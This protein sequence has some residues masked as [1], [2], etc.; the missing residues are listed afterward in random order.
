MS[1]CMKGEVEDNS[2]NNTSDTLHGHHTSF[3]P[4]DGFVDG[5]FLAGKIRDIKLQSGCW[6]IGYSP[7]ADILAVGFQGRLDF[8]ETRNYTC[9]HSVER[10]D[11]VSAIEWCPGSALLGD[12]HNH[13]TSALVAVAGLGNGQ[14]SVYQLD[15]ASLE[16][17]GAKVLHEFYM[18]AQV[19]SMAFK[20]LQQSGSIVLAI[21][22][23]SGRIA[24]CT[25][26][27]NSQE[28]SDEVVVLHQET[29]R[30]EQD[31][32]VLGLDVQVLK[33]DKI[34]LACSTKSGKVLI[35]SIEWQL[36][37]KRL[38]FG[39][40]LWETQ[41]NG[42]VRSLTFSGS[43]VL[44]GGYDK[45]LVIVDTNLMAITQDQSL[46]GT[47]N[48]IAL[49]PMDRFFVVGCRDK[50]LTFFDTSTCKSVKRLATKGW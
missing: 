46:Q 33:G 7:R 26:N 36:A 39:P 6:V 27:S 5:D 37:D 45:S 13:T 22:D 30:I 18:E 50:S 2:N 38:V 49:D 19:R 47:I 42:P 41:R 10:D 8:L 31:D 25:I 14:V 23:K 40:H 4:P 24:L 11:K 28:K 48:I 32:T 35:Y 44:F 43:L 16:F 3:P 1:A 9:I 20:P 12:Q 15:V 34:L 29:H 17:E 21:G